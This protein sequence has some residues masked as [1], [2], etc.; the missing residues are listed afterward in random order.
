MTAVSP[1]LAEATVLGAE[2]LEL[3]ARRASVEARRNAI[4]RLIVDW[5]D[6]L[7]VTAARGRRGR[8]DLRPERRSATC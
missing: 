5:N 1:M 4:R 8:R 3:G 2:D 7:S 6:A